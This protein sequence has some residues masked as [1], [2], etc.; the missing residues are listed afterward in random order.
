VFLDWPWLVLSLWSNFHRLINPSP[1][2][3]II[4]QLSHPDLLSLEPI[5]VSD[6]IVFGFYSHEL[7]PAKLSPANQ[8]LTRFFNIF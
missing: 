6:I 5:A 7:L 8:S 4:C 2:L 3:T 1:A